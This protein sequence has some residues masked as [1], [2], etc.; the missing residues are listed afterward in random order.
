M[1][2]KSKS[3]LNLWDTVRLLVVTITVNTYIIFFDVLSRTVCPR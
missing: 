3:G 2:P 1:E